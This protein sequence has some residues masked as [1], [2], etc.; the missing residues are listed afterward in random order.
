MPLYLS[1][2]SY[3]PSYPVCF[4]HST[5]V[6]LFHLISL[7]LTTC[8]LIL[9]PLIDTLLHIPSCC[10]STPY[11]PP[12]CRY[13]TSLCI[14][15]SHLSL[16]LYHFTHFSFHLNSALPCYVPSS[17]ISNFCFSHKK[18]LSTSQWVS[19][20]VTVVVLSILFQLYNIKSSVQEY[21]HIH[22]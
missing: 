7:L 3:S 18:S 16:P 8:R 11:F 6:P 5:F 4:N 13:F 20:H 2:Q 9:S 1:I 15:S 14:H 12:C 17:P 21:T 19:I 10:N 22:S